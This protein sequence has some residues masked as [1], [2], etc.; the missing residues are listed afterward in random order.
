[1]DEPDIIMTT[2]LNILALVSNLAESRPFKPEGVSRLVG[3]SL[4]PEPAMSNEYFN[5]YSGSVDG[6]RAPFQEV[7]LRVPTDK[8]SRKDGFLLCRVEPTVRVTREEV[9]RHFGPSP[10]LAFPSPRE[11]PDSPVYLVYS[12][13]W[14][15]LSFG[16]SNNDAPSLVSVVLDADK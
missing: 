1:M 13:P 8:A 10:E 11:P 12:R 7:E 14:G 3:L 15:S 6:T 2:T 4:H 9:L 5:I 16:F